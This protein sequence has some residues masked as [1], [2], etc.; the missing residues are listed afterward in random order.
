M[1]LPASW[2]AVLEPLR[3]AF[4]RRGTSTLFT[5][6]ATGM[7]AQSGRRSRWVSAGVAV[8]LRFCSAPVCLPVLCRWWAGRGTASPVELARDLMA[9]LVAEFGDRQVHGVGD[10]A[11]RGEAL[12]VSGATWTT[13]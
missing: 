4:R 13:G 11:Y 10:A 12:V 7:V 5:M 3:G 1:I 8:R 6:L 2:A 9:L